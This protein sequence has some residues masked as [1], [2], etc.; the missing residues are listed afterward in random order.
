MCRRGFSEHVSG[1]TA[2]SCNNFNNIIFTSEFGRSQQS[3]SVTA[4]VKQNWVTTAGIRPCLKLSQDT[5][6]DYKYVSIFYSSV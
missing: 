4:L 5:F 3:H 1:S 2:A 6:C